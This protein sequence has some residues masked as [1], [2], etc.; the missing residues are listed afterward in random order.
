M[1][2]EL[3]RP[4]VNED[5]K[6]YARS[7]G[8]GK[9]LANR[10]LAETDHIRFGLFGGIHNG[11]PLRARQFFPAL[12]PCPQYEGENALLLESEF[13]NRLP[14]VV[15]KLLLTDATAFSESYL[16]GIGGNDLE[17]VANLAVD[18]AR[19]KEHAPII[20]VVFGATTEMPIRGLSYILSPLSYMDNLR[21]DILPM[22]QLQVIFAHHLSSELNGMNKE[23]KKIVGE[24]A[25]KLAAV[26]RGFINGAYPELADKVVFAEDVSFGDNTQYQ[27]L[28]SHLK[29]VA[30]VAIDPKTAEAL[31]AKA[32]NNGNGANSL[33]YASA[34][35]LMHDIN[36][37][38]LLQPLFT[39]QSS[40]MLPTAIISMGGRQEYDFYNIR[41]C[42]KQ[43]LI[44]NRVDSFLPTI[45][46]FT[47]HHTPPYIPDRN[48]DILLDDV[49]NGE[50]IDAKAVGVAASY[51]LRYLERSLEAKGISIQEAI[52]YR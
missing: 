33:S 28:L 20:R 23:D 1:N 27:E 38:D 37:P 25:K 30:E 3:Q 21:G 43:V 19:K 29:N 34:H 42:V 8:Y 31:Q 26:A 13:N 14:K 36:L 11:K 50:S 5:I 9:T 45:Q 10:L 51:D 17:A 18:I 16:E 15:G 32:N 44:K 39:D 49:V 35:I 7:L 24:Q 47:R 41:Q 48:G 52:S 46:F 2:V 22:P 6:D 40:L 12:P 4:R